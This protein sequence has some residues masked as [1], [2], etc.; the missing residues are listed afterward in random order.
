MMPLRPEAI[1]SA[2]DRLVRE[3]PVLDVHTHLYDPA[4]SGFLL[5]GI[6][7][8]LNYHYLV[9]EAVRYLAMPYSQ[10]SHLSPE[11][12]TELIWQQLF[13]EHSPVSEACRGVLTTLRRLGLDPQPN[14]LASIRRWYADQRSEP[15]LDRVLELAGVR[16]VIMTNS[17]FDD[18]ERLAW[19]HGFARDSRFRAALR[20]D[21]LLL[22][23][24]RTARW[25][26]AQGYRVTSDFGG[27]TFGEI[28]RFLSDWSKTLDPVYMVVSLP[29]DFRVPDQT[30]GA[31]IIEHALIPHC[32]EFGQ[33]VALLVGVRRQVN[34]QLQ[35]A[36]DGVGV[37]TL[38]PYL[39]LCAAYP[40]I[41]F[42]VT[43]LS[44]ENQHELCVLARKF[45]NLHIF[46]CWWFSNTPSIIDEI[47]R[48]RLELLGL[49]FTPQH[50]DAR[51][52]EQ[53]IYKWEHS[54]ALIGRVLKDKYRDLAATGWPVTAEALERDV[55]YL[56]GGAF[57]HF[58]R[59]TF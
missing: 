52:L 24:E 49:S 48:E 15:F 18:A 14:A 23:W 36:G 26:R 39:Y 4:M 43:V 17:P 42:L 54:R 32:A 27:D 57:E 25:L 28:R 9:A 45:R 40:Q 41:K 35:L 46:G 16:A 29:P 47:T 7:A 21:P 53:L 11:Q 37:A 13:V 19:E 6:D 59:T 22:D 20:L 58:V 12:R 5:W 8:L 2:I 34:P 55:R 51:V 31:Q 44:R 38:Q 30:P 1:D 33:P 50:S 3:T 10:F 56:F